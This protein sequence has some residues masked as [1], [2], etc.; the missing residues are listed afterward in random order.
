M[1]QMDMFSFKAEPPTVPLCSSSVVEQKVFKKWRMFEYLDGLKG[2]TAKITYQDENVF[3]QV[4]FKFKTLHFAST[5]I[6]SQSKDLILLQT[7][8]SN[9]S[10][11]SFTT[12]S[13]EHLHALEV[14]DGIHT[15]HYK[16]EVNKV[17]ELCSSKA[18]FELS[19]YAELSSSVNKYDIDGEI[20]QLIGKTVQAKLRTNNDLVGTIQTLPFRVTSFQVKDDELTIMGTNDTLIRTKGYRGVRYFFSEL[21]LDVFLE[22]SGYTQ[23]IHLV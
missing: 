3:Y 10:N 20:S 5:A 23:T 18:T 15:F 8:L 11:M 12:S 19:N 14:K 1:E 7:M 17:L 6:S 21:I 4:P 16:S 22:G 2:K 13:K 9:S